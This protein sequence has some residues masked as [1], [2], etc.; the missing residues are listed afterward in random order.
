MILRCIMAEVWIT[1]TEA[2]INLNIIRKLSSIIVLLYIQKAVRYYII[3][4]KN[5]PPNL[6]RTSVHSSFLRQENA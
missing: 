1:Q 3:E 2:L 6:R 4:K 5:I